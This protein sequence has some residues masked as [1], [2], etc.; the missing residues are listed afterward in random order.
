M[1]KKK[2]VLILSELKNM[3]FWKGGRLR[4]LSLFLGSKKYGKLI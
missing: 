1:Q 3:S 4:P 2:T